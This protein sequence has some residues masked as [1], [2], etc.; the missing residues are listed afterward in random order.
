MDQRIFDQLDMLER[1]ARYETRPDR[2]EQ[3]NSS[4]EYSAYEGHD[5]GYGH[6]YKQAQ[7]EFVDQPMVLDSFGKLCYLCTQV[8]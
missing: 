6:D 5:P 8:C 1:G 7:D 4:A 3:H 2:D